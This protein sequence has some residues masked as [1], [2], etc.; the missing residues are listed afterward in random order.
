MK[1]IILQTIFILFIINTSL[2]A[3]HCGYDNAYITVLKITNG[4]DPLSIPNLKVGVINPYQMR[5]EI[6]KGQE[7]LESDTLF[8]KQNPK[9]D[10]LGDEGEKHHPA[11]YTM[12]RFFFAEN[13]YILL[14][15]KPFSDIRVYIESPDEEYYESKVVSIDPLYSFPLCSHFSRWDMDHNASFVADY[16]PFEISFV[17]EAYSP[18]DPSFLEGNY[19][20]RKEP[21][22]VNG[23]CPYTK[24]KIKSDHRFVLIDDELPINDLEI[25]NTSK[26][27]GT[28]TF[29]SDSTLV[30]KCSQ[31]T[32]RSSRLKG[33]LWMRKLF[34]FE[35]NEMPYEAS[36]SFYIKNGELY[37]GHYGFP[38]NC[39]F[40]KA[41]D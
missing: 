16:K 33:P 36:Y 21:S 15:T 26:T 27:Y 23:N 24:I 17:P 35:K 22:A 2:K 32:M 8:L 41:L 28:F 4:K 12:R 9:V 30:F 29:T 34:P 37:F 6:K 38:Y 14:S 19:L 10:R 7:F 1:N 40:T 31:R 3:Q 25:P 11:N 20:V 13:H 5:R 39:A 18:P